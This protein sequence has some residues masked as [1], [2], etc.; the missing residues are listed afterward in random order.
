[1]LALVPCSSSLAMGAAAAGRIVPTNLSALPMHAKVPQRMKRSRSCIATVMASEH[2]PRHVMVDHLRPL[3][4]TS[5]NTPARHSIWLAVLSAIAVAAYITSQA[6]AIFIIIGFV[7]GI[8][9]SRLPALSSSALETL[10]DESEMTLLGTGHGS[11]VDATQQL[12]QGTE[13][14]L[15][16]IAALE[17]TTEQLHKDSGKLSD[18][19]V[20]ICSDIYAEP[21]AQSKGPQHTE[22][23]PSPESPGSHMLSPSQS[24]ASNSRQP[25]PKSDYAR[26]TT[27]MDSRQLEDH[28]HGSSRMRERILFLWGEQGLKWFGLSEEQY[29]PQIARA[30]DRETFL[31]RHKDF[32]ENA[33]RAPSESPSEDAKHGP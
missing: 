3:R 18:A 6:W 26:W 29:W 7:A 30:A 20:Q 28:P 23:T 8:A 31:V 11:R 1:M 10:R 2:A 15:L 9:F 12:T 24:S 14:L 17:Q 32:L 19:V 25:Q 16:R 4:R 21:S 13:E 5:A 33:L 22:T 27:S